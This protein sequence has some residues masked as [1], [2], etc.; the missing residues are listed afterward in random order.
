MPKVPKGASREPPVAV[1]SHTENYIQLLNKL[2]R[3]SGHLVGAGEEPLSTSVYLRAPPGTA[4]HAPEVDN[5][6]VLFEARH[7]AAEAVEL[8]GS[9]HVVH[10]NRG[11]DRKGRPMLL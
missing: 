1:L 5:H 9:E 8:V 3:T 2:Y 7:S 10:N 11:P 4:E 6:P